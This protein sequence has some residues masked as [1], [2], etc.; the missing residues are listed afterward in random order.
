MRS[1]GRVRTE[2][3]LHGRGFLFDALRNREQAMAMFGQDEAVR[4]AVEQLDREALF[5]LGDAP[6]DGGV[7][8]FQS[9]RG[10]RKA[11]LTCQFQEINQIVPIEHEDA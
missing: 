10:R 7:V 2:R 4:L 3:L 5:Q 8:D 6:A 9:P 1:R 11:A